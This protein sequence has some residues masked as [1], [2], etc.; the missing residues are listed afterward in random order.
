[1]SAYLD[2][3][4]TKAGKSGIIGNS[5][6]FGE[7]SMAISITGALPYAA[8]IVR[9]RVRPERTT[10]LIWSL[11]LALAV[12]G[13]RAT[14]ASDSIWFIVGELVIT[15]GIF[16]LSLWRGMGGWT[17][18]DVSCLFIA[19]LSLLVW[20]LADVPIIG[21]WGALTADAVALVPTLIKA[22]QHPDSESAVTYACSSV[23]ALFG[24]LAVGEWNLVLLFYPV[25]LLLANFATAM[26][27]WVGQYQVNRLTIA[28]GIQHDRFKRAN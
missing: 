18:L 7:L 15:V 10:W 4:F 17:R 16:A 13:Y 1:L 23:A 22:L 2:N 14:G 28:E 27:V 11:I 24:I 9:G 21:V 3:I 25:Y 26:V 12:W 19:G 5:M 20:Q 6:T 8:Q